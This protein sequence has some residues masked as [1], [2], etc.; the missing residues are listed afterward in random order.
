[1]TIPDATGLQAFCQ[2]PLAGELRQKFCYP[3]GGLKGAEKIR[4][5]KSDCY[6]GGNGSNNESDD[7]ARGFE[8]V[9]AA[10]PQCRRRTQTKAAGS[11]ARAAGLSSQS[12]NPIITRCE[13]GARA[14]N[15]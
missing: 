12:G 13:G 9:A 15:Y 2:R 3:G 14:R 1:M 5:A 4:C 7:T 11:S 6:R 10:L 8:E